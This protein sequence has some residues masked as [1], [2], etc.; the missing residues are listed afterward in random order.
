[1]V[2]FADPEQSA[3]ASDFDFDFKRVG[4]F[5]LIDPDG[6]EVSQHTTI[7][8]AQEAGL[9]HAIDN[10]VNGEYTIEPPHW[11]LRTMGFGVTPVQVFDSTPDP[12]TFV[13]K[14]DQPADTV[15]ISSAVVLFGF[16]VP[17]TIEV[18]D[19]EYSIDGAAFTSSSGTVTVGQSIRARHTTGVNHASITET[20]VTVGGVSG[21][22][23][24]TVA[25]VDLG[26]VDFYV[27]A[28]SDFDIYTANPTVQEQ[29]W[30]RENYA[31]MQTYRPYFDSRLSWYPDAWFYKD[32]YAI[33]PDWQVFIDHPEWVLRD[34]S[35]NL[36]YIP[37][38]CSGGTCPQY[39]ADFGNPDFQAWWIAE[40]QVG[41]DQ[42]YAGIWVD[43]V[44]LVWRVSDGNGN[45]VN[46]IDPRTSIAMTET[47]YR[48]YFAEFMEAIRAAFPTVE[49][50]HNS[51][52]YAPPTDQY[53]LRQIDACD[54]INIERGVTDSGIT[55]GSG[56]FGFETFLAFIDRV[57]GRGKSVIMDDKGSI[58]DPEWFYELAFYFLIKRGGDLLC[59]DGDRSRMSPNNLDPIY[60]TNLG[61]ATS[62][63]YLWNGLYRRDYELGF[64]LVNP[65]GA[66]TINVNL[67][68]EYNNLDR[69]AVDSVSMTAGSGMVFTDDVVT[70]DTSRIL[71][72]ESRL[73]DISARIAADPTDWNFMQGRC[74]EYITADPY[75]A[76]FGLWAQTYMLSHLVQSN[77]A[78]RDRAIDLF[79]RAYYS[80][81]GGYTDRNG[82]R[83]AGHRAI[84]ALNWCRPY[85][86]AGDIAS[87]ESDQS[88]WAAYWLNYVD[89]ANGYANP[90]R[91]TADSDEW[92]S[93]GENFTL[94]GYSL[95]ETAGYQ[96][97][98]AD[99]LAAGDY[100]LSNVIIGE[101][102][103][104]SG[105]GGAWP[106]GQD[107]SA[108]TQQ[109]WIR[110]F[111]YNKD[112]R[113]IPFP[114]DYPEKTLRAFLHMTLPGHTEMFKYS[115]EE[116]ATDY[117][118]LLED[119]RYNFALHLFGVLSNPT[120]KGL[121]KYWL[122][123][124][125]AK[126]GWPS[127]GLQSGIDRVLWHEPAVTPVAPSA[128]DT[129]YD[130]GGGT[131]FIA[132]RSDWTDSAV[133]FYMLNRGRHVDHEH[134]D[135]LHIEIARNGAW[136]SKE[137]T[138]YGGVAWRTI[139]HNSVLIN[140]G[141]S[142]A[143][144]AT[145][146]PSG[147]G[148]APEDGSRYSMPRAG[149]FPFYHVVENDSASTRI[150][151]EATDVY[152]MGGYNWTLFASLVN[153]QVIYIKPGVFV[154]YD[155][156]VTDAAETRDLV[157]KGLPTGTRFV[158]VIQHFYDEPAG[159]GLNYQSND[160]TNYMTYRVAYPTNATVT[161]VD[162]SALWAGEGEVGCP[163]NQRRW[164]LQV[165]GAAVAEEN[166]YITCIAVDG[167]QPAI[168]TTPMTIG[169][170]EITGGNVIGVAIDV[171]GEKNIC[172]F[173]RAPSVAV[174][175]GSISRPSGF[176]L[177][178]VHAVGF[179][180]TG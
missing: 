20:T 173:N 79:T 70:I 171:D 19:G 74:A 146:Y 15:V 150:S 26:T 84:P 151:A 111:I 139:A 97:L 109:H 94:L 169:G 24:T 76:N 114:T 140:N 60:S 161:K 18:F 96:S 180:V 86:S 9:R 99:C 122:D 163:V 34:A 32:S 62:D 123:A 40:A 134:Y 147:Y 12:F 33:K 71:L 87:W 36:L 22:F 93:L 53:V 57:H 113:G 133:S 6:N 142:N 68:K 130:A 63:R 116:A 28:Q 92:T 4:R 101:Y 153:R 112:R 41:L 160:G 58:T 49:L 91:A 168:T 103:N 1:M 132:S 83:G 77:T 170:G 110:T 59:A 136:L 5:R 152:N 46:P 127:S 72:T 125:V 143:E 159:S 64:V 124:A 17:V 65:P 29:D 102:Q 167:S 177:A 80:S 43:D 51:I 104:G 56:T 175:G 69:S 75:A 48:R 16:N 45:F 3:D 176:S 31:R 55:G 78:H 157:W 135:A 118:E 117:Q 39:A 52:W 162:E 7:A 10:R 144:H 85:L 14:V 37:W 178:N 155:H 23:R 90:S 141:D 128:L 148:Y 108:N 137:M 172:L 158:R 54:Y 21:V 165:E 47:N 82:W 81:W 149:V 89:F 131:G 50:A 121:I 98:G 35:N 95:S 11:S 13:D 30:M 38:G 164:H 129:F 88:T 115:D 107:Y 66:T 67:D 100:I 138:G 179:T 106:E 42:G 2:L 156:T 154:I 166:E 25:A 27:D 44:N 105:K 174:S 119:Y 126:E 8:Y 145:Q 73:A 120:D 61:G